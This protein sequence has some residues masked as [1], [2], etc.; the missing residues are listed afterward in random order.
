LT[1]IRPSFDNGGVAGRLV[2]IFLAA[3]T[4]ALVAVPVAQPA[5]QTPLAKRL[6]AALGTSGADW[7]RTAALVVELDSG[8]VV[9]A[10]NPST[11]LR[12]ASNEKLAVTFAALTALGPWYR[13]ETT[14][15]GRGRLVDGVWE[16][17]LILRGRGDPTLSRSGLAS[18]A[19][20]V[21]A[22]GVLAV[23][24]AIRYDETYFDA[25]RVAFGWKASFYANESPPL[26]ALGVDRSTSSAPAAEAAAAFREALRSAG[27]RARGPVLAGRADSR[28][29]PLASILSPSVADLVHTMD[30]ESDNYTAELLIKQLGA[31]VARRGTTPAGSAVVTKELVEAGVPVGGV[32]I[33]D[34]SGLSR[35]DRLTADALASLLRLAYLDPLVRPSFLDAL[36]V[37]GLTGTLDARMET[38]PARGNVLAKTG[39][40]NEASA[41]S[42]YVKRRY[43]FAI[44]QNGDPI[45]HGAA[46]RSQDRFATILASL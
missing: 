11:P 12:P 13:I 42:G 19:A 6:A 38:P 43:A 5:S 18:L 44:V 32:R 14:V 24:G 28:S 37:A 1:G 45:A 4:A 3:V 30:T 39:T 33:V 7:S 46:R 2:R 36:A 25:R 22:E 17:D 8:R 16:G 23:T 20:Q 35:F 41:L 34:G 15:L 21:R 9:Y 26:S 31:V 10:Q 29:F 27:V 40:T